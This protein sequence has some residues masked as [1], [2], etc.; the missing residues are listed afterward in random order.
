MNIRYVGTAKGFIDKK[1]RTV[2]PDFA[3]RFRDSDLPLEQSPWQWLPMRNDLRNHSPDGA[4][5]GYSGSGPAQLA[6]ALLAHATG[7]DE[8]A[9]K[10]YQRFKV[11]V[12]SRW[13]MGKDW[14][15]DQV[16]VLEWLGLQV[17]NDPIL[18]EDG[19]ENSATG[20]N[21]GPTE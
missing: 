21:G 11:D 15:M 4:S 19:A 1:G 12:V 2:R 7:D 16:A 3:V 17:V 5:W 20:G 6:L 18:G 14:E 8:L 9:Q 10:L 13:D